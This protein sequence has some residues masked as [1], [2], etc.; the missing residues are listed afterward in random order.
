MHPNL[1]DIALTIG[2]TLGCLLFSQIFFLALKVIKNQYWRMA[3][4]YSST[5]AL[6]TVLDGLDNTS[7]FDQRL[8]GLMVKRGIP[9]AIIA[10]IHILIIRRKA[11]QQPSQA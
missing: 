11:R 10:A 9:L 6:Y 2:D 8:V 4:A 3:L 7:S 1:S 5:I